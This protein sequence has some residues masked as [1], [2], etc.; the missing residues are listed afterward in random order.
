MKIC[1][2]DL[3]PKSL[4][5]PLRRQEGSTTIELYGDAECIRCG[6]CIEACRMIFKRRVG[7]T[8]PLR[9]GWTTVDAASCRV[10]GDGDSAEPVQAAPRREP[11]DAHPP[12]QPIH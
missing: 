11:S 6:D 5:T 4:G 1:P 2:V 9:F 3:D 12:H 7:E 10:S 8:P